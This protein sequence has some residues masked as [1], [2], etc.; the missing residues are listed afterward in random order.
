MQDVIVAFARTGDPSTAA[1]AMPRFNP[2]AVRRV[3]FGDTI[4]VE[5]LNGEA[6]A[7]L[8][9]N[10]PVAPERPPSPPPGRTP[11]VPPS[12]TF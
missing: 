11:A 7:F 12:P 8:L 5:R 3:D 10:R 6:L 2:R 1:V 4:Q 9:A